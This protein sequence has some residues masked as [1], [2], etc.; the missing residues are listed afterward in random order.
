M[1]KMYKKMVEDDE[2]DNKISDNNVPLPKAFIKLGKSKYMYNYIKNGEI[3]FSPAKVF[4]SMEE[5]NDKIADSYEGSLNY[6]IS[7]LVIAPIIGES[8]NGT[9]I[10]GKVSKIADKGRLRWTNKALQTIPFH[11][12][13]CYEQPPINAVIRLENY[14]DIVREF[15]D[16]DSAVII[17]NVT[18]F[19]NRIKAKFEIYCNRVMYTDTTPSESD[20]ENQIHPLFY[21]RKL[22]EQQK[23]FRIALPQLRI[24]EAQNYNIGSIEDIAYCVPLRVLKHGIIIAENDDIF[25]EIKDNCKH[26]GFMVGRTE[27]LEKKH[28]MG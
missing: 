18:E 5:G 26:S 1:M 9:P 11:C 28:C 10:Y 21:K 17:Y 13:Y 25:E 16:Y 14:D 24:D 15:P 12:L 27:R 3:R 2:M 23:E 20:I 6:P 4:T 22:F 8:E 19:L 7:H